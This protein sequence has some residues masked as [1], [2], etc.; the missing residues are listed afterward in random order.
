MNNYKKP[1]FYKWLNVKLREWFS[2]CLNNIMGLNYILCIH[3][4]LMLKCTATFNIT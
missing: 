4:V 1:S 2:L 3:N